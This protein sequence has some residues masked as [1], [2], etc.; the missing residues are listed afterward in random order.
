[1]IFKDIYEYI[2]LSKKERQKHID[3]NTPCV[4]IGGYSSNF[5]GMLA[6]KLKTTIPKTNK[7]HLCHACN[8]S[9]CSNVSHLYWGTNVENLQDSIDAGILGT[10]NARTLTIEK[11]GLEKTS[12]LNKKASRLGGK[13]NIKPKTQEH[14]NN[15]SKTMKNNLFKH[16]DESKLKMSQKRKEW[17]KNKKSLLSSM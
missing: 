8:N 3:L 10:K 17:H 16:S 14:R 13:N 2:K 5:R 12:I 6:L 4:E 1:M 7:I 15:I 9:K 11:H